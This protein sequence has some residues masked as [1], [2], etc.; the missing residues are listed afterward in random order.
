MFVLQYMVLP[1]LSEAKV[2]LDQFEPPEKL[3]Q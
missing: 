2:G 3:R 1:V